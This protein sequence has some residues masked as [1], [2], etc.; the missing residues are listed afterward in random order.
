[1][2]PNNLQHLLEICETNNIDFDPIKIS[3]AKWAKAIANR[4]SNQRSAHLYITFTNAEVT[5]R[6]ITDGLYICHKKCQV[7]KSKCEPTRCLKCQGWNHLAKDC[8]EPHDTC[9]NCTGHHRTNQCSSQVKNCVSCKTDDH[10]SW[11]QQC[12]TFVKKAHE[13]N[14]RSLDNSTIYFPTTD[15]WT[16][17]TR[18]ESSLNTNSLPHTTTQP[19]PTNTNTTSIPA[20]LPVY[21]PLPCTNTPNR[22]RLQPSQHTTNINYPNHTRTNAPNANTVSER[23]S[24]YQNSTLPPITDLPQMGP[25]G[26]RIEPFITE[27]PNG[28]DIPTLNSF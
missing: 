1:M 8:I 7:E 28:V 15:P 17:T 19:K 9:G 11:S 10:P 4:N 27:D 5:N 14:S 3:S 6:A 24:N 16:W 21:K 25:F 13:L 18:S 2:D 20:Y 22:H 23:W 12:P 26:P